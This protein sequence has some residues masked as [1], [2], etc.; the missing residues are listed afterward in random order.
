MKKLF[1]KLLVFVN[2][3]QAKIM[4]GLS[5]IGTINSSAKIIKS[6]IVSK[7]YTY[8]VYLS[9]AGTSGYQVCPNATKECMMGCLSNSGRVK[10]EEY[11]GKSVIKKARIK[12]TK[13]FFEQQEFF[14]RW[15]VA[16]IISYQ[17]KA[18]KD[19]YAFSCRLN[20]T[21]D[22]DW[23]EIYLDGKNIF[24]IFPD[25]QFYDYTKDAKR[26]VN[27]P[28]N[29][30]LTFSYSGRNEAMS[31]KLLA[32]GFNVAVV[33]D[34]PDFPETWNGFPVINGDLTDYRPLDG[35]GVVVG[36]KYKKLADNDINE[37][38]KNSCFVVR[39]CNVHKPEYNVT[40]V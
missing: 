40:L 38:V 21:S 19:G 3:A 15:M 9:P 7:V 37:Y 10:V 12:K 28:D 24:E 23:T 27:M 35:S 5:Y 34:T 2:R 29:Y 25:V 8:I 14:M 13:L 39:T 20:G 1:T 22:I 31:K 4:T 16:E 6:K 33:F 11:A 36:L 30:H 26:F 17:K 18:E 32:Q